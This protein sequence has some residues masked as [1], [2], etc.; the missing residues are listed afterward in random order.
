MISVI[1]VL[2]LGKIKIIY[3]GKEVILPVEL[4]LQAAKNIQDMTPKY[5]TDKE[6]FKPNKGSD[7]D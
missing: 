5:K 1:E 2:D 7:Y 4:V 6:Y 3:N